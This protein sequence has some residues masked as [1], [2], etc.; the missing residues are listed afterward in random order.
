MFCH[1]QE[2]RAAT[3]MYDKGAVQSVHEK[4]MSQARV[5][6]DLI[7]DPSI[8][9]A[10][11]VNDSSTAQEIQDLIAL[12][13]SGVVHPPL[14]GGALSTLA[15]Y[16][17]TARRCLHPGCDDPG[18][19]GNVVVRGNNGWDDDDQPEYACSIKMVHFKSKYNCCVLVVP[20]Y[21]PVSASA[22][23]AEFYIRLITLYVDDIAVGILICIC[24]AMNS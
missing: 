3:A 7:D 16:G 11:L 9:H 1:A 5:V 10:A 8:V 20:L 15:P 6:I 23:N 12:G 18:C 22:K 2:T 4:W 13:L 24:Y 14:R 19:E 17:R 21:A